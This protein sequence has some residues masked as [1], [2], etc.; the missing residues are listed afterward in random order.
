MKVA[1]R[2]HLWLLVGGLSVLL[3]PRSFA[4][5]FF[6]V[7]AHSGK[8]LLEAGADQKRAIS[9]LTHLATGI[10]VVDWAKFSGAQLNQLIPVVA[11]G[12]ANPMGLQPGDAIS[13]REALYSM[14]MGSDAVS[15]ATLARHAGQSIAQRAGGRSPDGAFVTQMNHLAATLGMTSTR[16]RDPVGGRGNTSTARDLA[17]LAVYASRNTS[18]LF[19]VKQATRNISFQ[20][21]SQK[22][23]FRV[24]NTNPL[25]GKSGIRGMKS[26]NDNLSGPSL[27][28]TAEKAP[29]VLQ[30]ED[31]RSMIT[32]RR[33][34]AVVLGSPDRENRGLALISEGWSRHEGWRTT[35]GAVDGGP[36]FLRV[37]NP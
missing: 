9:S 32:P 29:A 21:A 26:A 6:C 37:P 19:Y 27:I 34:I 24:Q 5:S 30:L 23:T 11:V 33:L 28:L 31:G 7:E 12:G 4:E 25:L 14:L 16:F 36:D 13:V 10:V 15:A 1:F 17:K 8:V 18:F 2:I 22:L 3:T 35:D 20:R